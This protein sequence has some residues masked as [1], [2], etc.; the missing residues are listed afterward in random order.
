[1]R[2]G[3]RWYDTDGYREYVRQ[4]GYDGGLYNFAYLA[5]SLQL[6]GEPD[7]AR[8]M[9]EEVHSRAQ[10]NGTPYGIALA[11]C[12]RALIARDQG[13]VA[14]A[15]DVGDRAIAQAMDQKLYYWLGSV[16]CLRG[17]ATIHGGDPAAGIAQVEH[18]LALFD[19]IGLRASYGYHLAAL[20][21]GHLATGSVE[22]GLAAVDR[23]LGLCETS[24]DRFYEPELLRLRGELVR[25]GGDVA[26]AERWLRRSL[27]LGAACHGRWFELRTATSLAR[28]L[29]ERGSRREA[30]G[31]L[32][33]IYGTFDGGLE[34]GDLRAARE[35]LAE[36][37]PEPHVSP[38]TAS[39][40]PR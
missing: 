23:A 35:L 34:T 8:A 25:R 11:L 32:S 9:V 12:F 22:P 1:M 24:L 36:L 4:Y 37:T 40:A 18:G 28:L 20:A 7:A 33:T 21:E 5:W 26:G 13:D 2:S 31:V 30:H 29:Q 14:T 19:L 38:V 16:T 15:I 17:W 6:L 3:L 27:E 39:L 10:A